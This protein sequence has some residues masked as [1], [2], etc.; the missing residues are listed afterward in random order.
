MLVPGVAQMQRHVLIARVPPEPYT[1]PMDDS[2]IA[3]AS[4]IH[5]C[6]RCPRLRQWCESADGQLARYRGQPY[7]G[8]P[9]AGFGDLSARL[10]VIGLAPGRHGANRT[11]RPFTGDAAGGWLYDALFRYGFASRPDALDR[12]DGL[13]LRDVYITNLVRCAPPG[14]KPTREEIQSCSSHFDQEMQLLSK[15]QG[16]LALGKVAFDGYMKWL[17]EHGLAKGPRRPFEHG[18]M[19]HFDGQVPWLMASYHCSQRNTRSGRLTRSMW[20]AL[21]QNLSARLES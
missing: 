6:Q 3:L 11:G 14:D 15:R 18:R 17:Y 12:E 8:K 13:V 21:F 19:Y 2:Y 20:D 1:K 4:R 16:I 9:V 7:W 10:V 5:A